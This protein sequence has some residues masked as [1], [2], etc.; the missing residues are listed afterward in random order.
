[1][2]VDD[3]RRDTAELFRE[4]GLEVPELDYVTEELL[5]AEAIEA[6][7]DGE[8]PEAGAERIVE[9]GVEIYTVNGHHLLYCPARY[10][11]YICYTPEC[12]NLPRRRLRTS[13]VFRIA[14]IG[15]CGYPRN[16]YKM[17]VR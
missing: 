4:H 12:S 5:A 6:E 1:M 2:S 9:A 17:F 11:T 10:K 14:H 3:A 16:K 8:D 15:Y 7:F 13:S